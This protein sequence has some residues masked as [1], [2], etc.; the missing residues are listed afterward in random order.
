MNSARPFIYFAFTYRFFF[1]GESG[2][3]KFEREVLMN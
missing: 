3:A 2:Q 1:T